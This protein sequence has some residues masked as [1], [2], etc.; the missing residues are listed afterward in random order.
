MTGDP[1]VERVFP[2]LLAKA[3]AHRDFVIELD[4]ADPARTAPLARPERRR[5]GDQVNRPSVPRRSPDRSCRRRGRARW[6]AQDSRRDRRSAARTSRHARA[7]RCAAAS[8]RPAIAPNT[9]MRS[10]CSCSGVSFSRSSA[11]LRLSSSGRCR[12]HQ[13]IRRA[14]V[15]LRRRRELIAGRHADDHVALELLRLSSFFAAYCARSPC[16]A[17]TMCIRSFRPGRAPVARRS[18]SRTLRRARSR[19]AGCPGRR[20][21]ATWRRT[22]LRRAPGRRRGRDQRRAQRRIAQ[23]HWP[24]WRYRWP[25]CDL[26]VGAAFQIRVQAFP[27]LVHHRAAVERRHALLGTA[28]HD[29]VWKSSFESFFSDSTS[30][31]PDQTF[32]LGAVAALARQRTPGLPPISVLASTLVPSAT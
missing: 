29:Q 14:H 12:M 1:L 19:R 3:H 4:L 32:L 13:R 17:E 8:P 9:P 6:C 23:G 27:V 24:R 11:V 26:P 25:G 5:A 30:G 7:G 22:L 10:V 18:C 21:R 31:G 15:R 20:R 2:F 28:V 16:A